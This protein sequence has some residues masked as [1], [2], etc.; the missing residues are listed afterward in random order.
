MKLTIK[1]YTR[2]DPH[3]CRNGGGYGYEEPAV[4]ENY[5][6]VDGSHWTTSELDYCEFCG[7]F[8]QNMRD[9][10]RICDEY[11]PSRQMEHA[12]RLL[13]ENAPEEAIV[14]FAEWGDGIT[15]EIE[16]D[17]AIV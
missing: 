3:R 5:Q 17:L 2:Y 13:G 4:I 9:H 16:T 7:L 12:V 8:Q 11:I 15:L 1:D 6:I 10:G 14:L